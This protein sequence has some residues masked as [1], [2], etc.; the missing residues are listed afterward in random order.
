V[1]GADDGANG[2]ELMTGMLADEIDFSAWHY[3]R[4]PTHVVFYQ[5]ATLRYLS[6]QHG[7]SCEFP[8]RAVALMQ[9]PAF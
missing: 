4:D 6:D 2:T 8:A 5:H 7:W 9:K 3:R 1:F